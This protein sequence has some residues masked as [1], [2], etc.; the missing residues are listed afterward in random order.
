[1]DLDT[2]RTAIITLDVQNDLV[3]GTEGVVETGMLERMAAIL[4]A[5]RAKDV[6]VI[7]V[8]ASAR[9]DFRDIPSNSPLW[10]NLRT[11]KSMIAGTKGAE[12]HSS[13]APLKSELVLNKT[14]VDPFLTTNLGQSLINSDVNTL[15]L[16]GLWTNYVV[17]ATA[18]HGSDMGYR[19]FVVSDCCASNNEEDHKWAIERILPT[20]VYIADSKE[21]I[22]ALES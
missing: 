16:F 12:I 22:S 11:Q 7:H 19:V 15:V 13:V 14:C 18:R 21:I 3:E 5:G 17:E 10:V 6:T 8:T 20:L 9:D 1:M 4:Q 2:K